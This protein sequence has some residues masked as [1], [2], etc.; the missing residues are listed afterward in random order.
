MSGPIGR[1]RAGRA[2]AIAQRWHALDIGLFQ[3]YGAES[4]VKWSWSSFM[5]SVLLTV[6]VNARSDVQ[7]H[8]LEL[9]KLL[10]LLFLFAHYGGEAHV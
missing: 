6:V 1:R 5:G 2:S 3:F 10:Q 8:S 7:R 9:A 4:D